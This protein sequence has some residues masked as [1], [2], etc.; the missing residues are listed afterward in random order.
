M[1]LTLGI[2]YRVHENYH[3]CS[4][5]DPGLTWTYFTATEGQVWSLVI[6]YG[7]KR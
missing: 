4:N 6:L 3:I 2:Q 5:D 1:T 7:E